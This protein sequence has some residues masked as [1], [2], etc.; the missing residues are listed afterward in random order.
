[1]IIDKQNEF[2]DAQAITSGDAAS[3]NIIDLGA[4]AAEIAAYVE[5]CSKLAI[6]VSEAFV[7]GTS[8]QIVLQ[9]DD[10]SDFGSAE[11]VIETPAILTA[12]LVI[13]KKISI[14]SLPDGLKRYVRLLYKAVGTYTAGKINAAVVAD[15]QTA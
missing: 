14:Q 11:D 10:A 7:G 9:T 15:R 4:D 1:M 8:L 6:S 5:K 2:S 3:E 13:G 12:D